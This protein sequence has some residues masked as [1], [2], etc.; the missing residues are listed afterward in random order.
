M[1][2]LPGMENVAKVVIDE[3]MI[4]GDAKPILIYADQPR[5]SGFN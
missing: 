3:N 1:Y 4:T 2:E 5:V